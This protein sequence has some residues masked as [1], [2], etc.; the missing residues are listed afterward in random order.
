MHLVVVGER[1]CVATVP[2]AATAVP[3]SLLNRVALCADADLIAVA[4]HRIS[5]LA[6]DPDKK[7]RD[8]WEPKKILAW[9]KCRRGHG[10]SS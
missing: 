2:T 7:V 5:M 3:S 10:S 8:E 1:L 9:A 6:N 4:N